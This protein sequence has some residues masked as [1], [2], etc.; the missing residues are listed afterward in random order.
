MT[1]IYALD[2]NDNVTVRGGTLFVGDRPLPPLPQRLSPSQAARL[3]ELLDF[4]H[5][6]LTAATDTIR[7][8]EE[9]T[10]V[11]LGFLEWQRVLAVQLLLARYARAV[12]EPDVFEE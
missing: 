4:L 5:R 9:G 10:E 3:A 6:H 12:A 8:N 1:A 11:V 2:L 7:S